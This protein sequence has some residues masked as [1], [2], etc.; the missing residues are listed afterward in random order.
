MNDL[1]AAW[2]HY[3]GLRAKR[4]ATDEKRKIAQ[5]FN[6][7]Y[8]YRELFDPSKR[9]LGYRWM[10]PEC[11]KIHE[12]QECS[13]FSGLQYP[14]CCGTGYGNRLTHGVRVK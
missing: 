10:C 13:V 1:T 4:K 3:L 6:D 5:A 2:H 9:L 7:L 11:N 14:A 8:T 12:P